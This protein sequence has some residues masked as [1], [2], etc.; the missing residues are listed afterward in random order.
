[1]ACEGLAALNTVIPSN[2]KHQEGVMVP[3]QTTANWE[4][5][6]L[7]NGS[8]HVNILSLIEDAVQD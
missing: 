1:M 3:P 8:Q 6:F 5:R 4:P 7:H 2:L